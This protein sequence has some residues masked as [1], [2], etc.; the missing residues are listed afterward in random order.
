MNFQE[1]ILKEIGDVLHERKE[2]I[3]VAESVTA[4]FLQLALS[5]ITEAS[6]VYKGGIT[7]YTIEEKIKLLNIDAA[8]AALKNCVSQSI[9]NQMAQEVAR[10]FDT[11]WAIATTGYASEVPESGFKLYAFCTIFH[12]DKIILSKKIELYPHTPAMDAQHFY[13]E[14][15]LFE[16][17]AVLRPGL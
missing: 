15:V 1:S 17:H 8:E 16:L 6:S 11:E 2:K 4:G 7:T 14:S 13:A 9:T 10:L 3:A 12:K 5:Q